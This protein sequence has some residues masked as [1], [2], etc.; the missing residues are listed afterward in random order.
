MSTAIPRWR[1][2]NIVDLFSTSVRWKEFFPMDDGVVA[3]EDFVM[4]KELGFNFVRIPMSYLFFGTGA[5]GRT[6]DPERLV[7]LDRVVEFGQKYGIHV[8]PGFHRAP[9]YCV[10]AG[11]QFD[12]PE[13]GNLFADD[14]ELRDF[15]TWWRTLAE[16]YAGVPRDALSFN[17]VN[18]PM[19]VDD[20]TF[21]RT[22]TPV[23]EA[24][25]AVSPHRLIQ[26]EGSFVWNG[27]SIT[28]QPA[29]ASIATRENVVNSVHLYHPMTLTHYECPWTEG[30]VSADLEP[31][32]WPY[33][34][35]VK[36]GVERVLTGDD[37]KRWD[38]EAL[39]ELLKGY[40]DLSTAGYKV[41]VGEMGAYSKVAHEVYLAYAKD[42]VSLLDEY[43]LGYA[44]WNFRGP[45]GVVDTGRTDA[46]AEEF[47]GHQLDRALADVLRGN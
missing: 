2:F 32:T 17:L 44:M 20:A 11:S 7:L 41:H 35:A 43:G 19:N 27:S 46:A 24:I 4:I 18:E 12:F 6:P 25:E 39:R 14:E 9:G 28:L 15:I 29:P 8:M 37:A 10:T 42:V 3:E 31:P 5:Y 22:F 33:Q 30:M 40:L 26:V 38:K 16:R 21:V 13:K 47:H 36:P 45:F 23:I 1:G 34:P